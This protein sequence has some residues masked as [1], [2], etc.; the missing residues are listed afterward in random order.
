MSG[1]NG[2]QAHARVREAINAFCAQ[3]VDAAPLPRELADAVRYAL[4]GGG[5]RLRPTL[6]WGACVACGGRGEDALPAGAAVELV[7]AFS[8]VHDD[9][10]A[11]D[12]DDLRRGRATL[13]KQMGEAMAILAGDQMLA[14]AFGALSAT[15]PGAPPYPPER[16]AALTRE[17]VSGTTGMIAG[18]CFDMALADT[19]ANTGAEAL[20]LVHRHK[21]GAL[22]RAACRM[23]AVCAGAPADDLAS[24]TEYADAVGLQFQVVD[25]LLDATGSTEDLGKLAGKDASVGKLTYPS[26]L[27]LDR[28]RALVGE[29]RERAIE[30]ISDFG[31]E[32]ALLRALAELLGQRRS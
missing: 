5:K 25:D 1:G 27:G 8:L 7:H 32:A 29:L 16:V 18:Q 26:V 11:M 21:T 4:L 2:Q 13:H 22:I 30:A 10:P 15:P 9:L 17:L 6:A 31:D 14:L 3:I 12:D 23:G 28:S 19:G 20:E 24:I